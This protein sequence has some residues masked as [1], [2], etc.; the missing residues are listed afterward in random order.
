LLFA[1]AL[2]LST[3][4][5]K[6]DDDLAEIAT[7]QHRQES[8]ADIVEPV[9]NVFAI[10][11]G[12]FADALCDVVKKLVIEVFRELIVNVPAQRE[13]LERMARI[14]AVRPSSPALASSY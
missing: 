11:N 4:F 14:V 8:G 7:V 5:G 3:V 2:W 10:A 1:D 9:H 6:F 12:T 13:T